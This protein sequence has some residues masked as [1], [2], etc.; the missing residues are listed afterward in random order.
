MRLPVT[1]PA[2]IDWTMSGRLVNI[3]PSLTGG[4]G[5]MAEWLIVGYVMIFVLAIVLGAF[6][7]VSVIGELWGP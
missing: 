3:Q 7:A 5:A 6:I 4:G 2:V 1:S